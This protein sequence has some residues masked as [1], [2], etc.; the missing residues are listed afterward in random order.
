MNPPFGAAG[1]AG[2]DLQF[3][4]AALRLCTGPVYLVH[5]AAAAKRVERFAATHNARVEQLAAFAFPLAQMRFDAADARAWRRAHS[6][7]G[8]APRHRHTQ[9]VVEID[10]VLLKL[11]RAPRL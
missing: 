6:D 1:N 11:T 9:A 10:C 8:R 3:V 5:K 7:S 4:A 2:V